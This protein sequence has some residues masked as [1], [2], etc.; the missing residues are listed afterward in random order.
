MGVDCTRAFPICINWNDEDLKDRQYEELNSRRFGGGYPLDPIVT[1]KEQ[2]NEGLYALSEF[3]D[4]Q[5]SDDHSGKVEKYAQDLIE[6]AKEVAKKIV[7]ILEMID[8]VPADVS[9]DC[10]LQKAIETT[11]ELIGCS[12]KESIPYSSQ[13]HIHNRISQEE[14]AFWQSD[15]VT[16]WC[17]DI[18]NAIHMRNAFLKRTDD[19]PNF[20]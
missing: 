4:Q 15:A 11:Q 6:N 1:P 16:K 5:K 12:K 20:S 2:I 14:D 13:M 3:L 8:R 18:D 9:I 17:E 10:N 19:I 7:H